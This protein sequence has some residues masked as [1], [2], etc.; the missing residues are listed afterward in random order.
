ML[1]S[2]DIPQNEEGLKKM[3]ARKGKAVAIEHFLFDEL[4]N[5]GNRKMPAEVQF[6]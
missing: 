5:F 1:L 4:W 3:S 2:G 6:K